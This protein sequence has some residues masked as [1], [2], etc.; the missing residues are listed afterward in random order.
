MTTDVAH[1]SVRG[2]LRC[3]RSYAMAEIPGVLL[4]T[5]FIAKM[6]R[7]RTLAVSTAAAG[8][9]LL[10]LFGCVGRTFELSVLFTARALAACAYQTVFV[11]TRDVFPSSL[12]STAVRTPLCVHTLVVLGVR[13]VWVSGA[14]GSDG[15]R[16]WWCDGCVTVVRSAS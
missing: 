11:Y 4:M 6:D 1:T 16:V 2:M 15:T 8:L 12:R 14:C 10:A 9:C 7:R 3:L 5:V 13:R